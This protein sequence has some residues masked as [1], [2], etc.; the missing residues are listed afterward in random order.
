M[1]GEDHA[2]PP[3]RLIVVGGAGGIGRAIVASAI[4][5][6]SRVIVLD[7]PRSLETH[8]PQGVESAIGVDA[9]DTGQVTAAFAE[10]GR[11][12]DGVDGL[13][14]LPGLL[15][16]KQRVEDF[17]LADW[18]EVVTTSLTSTFLT[19]KLGLALLRRGDSPS[20]VTMASSLGV[21]SAPGYGPYSAAKAA[22]ISLTR[23]LALEL[24][25]QIRVN[26]IAPGLVETA[27]QRGGTGQP[28]A[29]EGGPAHFAP[30]PQAYQPPL[31]RIA[32]PEDI[33]ATVLF[34]LSPESAIITGQ[35][36]HVN[37]GALMA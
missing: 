32:V 26:A 4:R 2:V 34:L 23:T 10:V 28:G 5:M 17:S 14:I 24:A 29:T 16:R 27:F 11:S 21:Q 20:I 1:P 30:S 22:V 15:R 8:P 13:V 36:I 19:V 6:G 7:L 18:N 33:A 37:G 35:V 9:T 3:P 12:W 31:G 25:P